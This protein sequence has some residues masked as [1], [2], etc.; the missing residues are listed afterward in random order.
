MSPRD[1]GLGSTYREVVSRTTRRERLRSALRDSVVSLLAYTKRPDPSDGWIRVPCYHHVFDDERDGF[2]RQLRYMRELGEFISLDEAVSLLGS[3]K[4]FHGRYFCITFDD[5]LRNCLTNATPILA[6][7][8]IVAAFFVITSHVERAGGDVGSL[9]FDDCRQLLDAGMTIGSHSVNHRRLVELSEDEVVA[10]LQL[11]KDLIGRTLGIECRHFCAPF[12]RPSVHFDVVRD[13]AIARRV[14]YAS[15]LTLA[16][17]PNRHG[18][19]PY[20][21]HRDHLLANW[22]L[23]QLKYFFGI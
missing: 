17:G 9:S 22:S 1:A 3:A 16:R 19:S 5:G 14:G 13:P 6:E 10:E 8:R 21:M 23:R 18:A 20:F 11:S 4:P 15:F 7:L 12:G 2:Q